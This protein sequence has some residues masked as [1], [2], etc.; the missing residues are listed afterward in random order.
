MDL[1]FLDENFNP[2]QTVTYINLQWNRR[3]FEC[4]QFSVQMLAK[5]YDK[6]YRYAYSPAKREL[7]IV[8]KVEYTSKEYGEFVQISGF[9]LERILNHHILFPT[10]NFSGTLENCIRHVLTTYCQGIPKF[11]VGTIDVPNTKISLQQTGEEVGNQLYAMLMPYECSFRLSY[12]YVLDKIVFDVWQGLD[13]TT[14]SALHD[15]AVFSQA[16]GGLKDVVSITDESN[17]KNF[18]I[19]AGSGEGEDRLHTVLDLT[20]GE[21]PRKIYIDARDLQ[22]TDDMTLVSYLDTLRQR[23][24]EKLKDYSNI[25]NVEFE[26]TGQLKYREHFDLGDK[27]DIVLSHLNTEYKARIIG[28]DEVIKENRTEINLLF[29]E[30]I[31]KKIRR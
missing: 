12:D 30:K 6:S 3:Y 29:G 8:Q 5:E 23:G 25:T 16:W 24:I 17:Y 10:L 31:P 14:D 28:I 19:I 11:Q 15:P 27:C 7:G 26:S 18:A 4:G 9:F 20:N 2:V 13:R 21:A 1:L 22:R